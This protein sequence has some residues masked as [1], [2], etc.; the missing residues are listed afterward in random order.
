MRNFPLTTENSVRADHIYGIAIPLIQGGMKCYRDPAVKVPK[1][2]LPADISLHHKDI[3]LCMD[4]YINGMP[5]LHKNFQ[6]QLPHRRKLQFKERRQ[7]RPITS[8]SFQ[9]VHVNMF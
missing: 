9:H 8:H 1:N 5:F 6:Y 3:E 2:P 4:F 7:D